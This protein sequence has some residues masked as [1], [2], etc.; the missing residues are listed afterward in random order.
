MGLRLS[1]SRAL[2]FRGPDW[3]FGLL[4]G[5]RCC[6]AAVAV[7]EERVNCETM[8]RDSDGCL[9]SSVRPRTVCLSAEREEF[10]REPTQS[11]SKRS[12]QS[13]R[14]SWRSTSPFCAG[15]MRTSSRSKNAA[16]LWLVVANDKKERAASSI[17][18]LWC[19]EVAAENRCPE[20]SIPPG[21]IGFV[22]AII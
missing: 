21:H 1:G 8:H 16:C 7:Y 22:A 17:I 9:I 14:E 18:Q 10:A 3:L 2:N 13:K 19:I 20:M 5:F 4:C 6:L 15:L 12:R 11:N